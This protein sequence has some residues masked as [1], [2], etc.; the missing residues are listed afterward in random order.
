MASPALLLLLLLPSAAPLPADRHAEPE[1]PQDA[2]Y[3]PD[4]IL[5][6]FFKGFGEPAAKSEPKPGPE[7][8]YDGYKQGEEAR[9]QDRS[10][11]TTEEEEGMVPVPRATGRSDPTGLWLAITGLITFLL[12]KK[13]AVLGLVL[14]AAAALLVGLSTLAG[15]DTHHDVLQGRV[16]DPS[17]AQ[18]YFEY[19]SSFFATLLQNVWSFNVA[20]N[21]TSPSIHP[22]D[23]SHHNNTSH[24]PT[25]TSGPI[26]GSFAA[27]AAKLV[28]NLTNSISD[29]VE[30]IQ[31]AAAE[32]AAEITETVAET[33]GT[34]QETVAN[35]TGAAA[36]TVGTVQETV[37]NATGA[38]AAAAAEVSSII[39]ETVSNA[40]G[41]T[42]A[43]TAAEL[44]SSGAAVAE[45]LAE[46]AAGVTGA[47]TQAVANVTGSVAQTVADVNETGVKTAAENKGVVAETVAEVAD[48][49]A[50]AVAEGTIAAAET[51]AEAVEAKDPAADL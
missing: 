8:G 35:A 43:T 39:V 44:V 5:A 51:V 19:F 22:T 40:T 46:T 3:H 42:A 29:T 18:S 25:D 7:L 48:T 16:D 38:A 49:V 41:T 34:V 37:A 27:T 15:V 36:E 32:T 31:E 23:A 10:D 30:N 12:K 14:G 24:H 47:A 13:V 11:T 50:E 45:T 4:H 1:E 26:A 2:A 6:S 21:Q 28:G 9:A 17:L 33:V 20:T